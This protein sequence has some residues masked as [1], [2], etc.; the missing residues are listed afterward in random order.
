MTRRCP[1]ALV[2]LLGLS[3]AH[4]RPGSAPDDFGA[5]VDDYF[6]AHFAFSPTEGTAAGFHEYDT[7]LEDRSRSR[8]DARI[9]ELHGEADHLAAFDRARLTADQRIDAEVLQGQIQGGLLEL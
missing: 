7:H 3:C 9:A 5:F 6:A 8:I 4:A 1:L 2:L